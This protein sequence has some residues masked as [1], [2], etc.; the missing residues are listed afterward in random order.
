MLAHDSGAASVALL[1]LDGLDDGE[2]VAD[3]LQ[4]H[5]G[6]ELARL[7][8]SAP[9]WTPPATED[10]CQQATTSAPWP[11][12]LGPEV[13]IGV[14]GDFLDLVEEQTEADP[15]AMVLDFLTR[16]GNVVGR[17]PHFEVSGDRHCCNLF[18]AVVGDTGQGRK[19]TSTAFAR[20]MMA[21]CFPE[22]S[23][24]CNK[25][26]LSSGEGVIWGV[27]DPAP[28]GKVDKG[29]EAIMDPG[30]VDKRLLVFEAELARTLRA[31]GRR[32]NTLMTMLRQAWEGGQ[33]ATM[34]KTPYAATGAHISLIMHVTK[35]E[36][37]SL[38]SKDDMHGG[39]ANRLLF[40]VSRRQ[41]ELPFGGK[42]DDVALATIATELQTCVAHAEQ[43][44]EM[45]FSDAARL[46]WPAIYHELQRDEKA[47]GILGTLLARATAQVRRLAMIFAIID[48][49]TEVDEHHIAAA[50]EV[51]RYCRQ[52]VHYIFGY[53]TGNHVA[54]IILAALRKKPSGI[55]RT[56]MHALFGKH[57]SAR[58]IDEAL[59]LLQNLGLGEPAKV[60]GPRNG[61][62]P[63][64][65]VAT[66]R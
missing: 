16:V 30:V 12:P 62:P 43:R 2:D 34:T 14:L 49:N 48:D 7:V 50:R 9:T 35:E 42:V 51:W 19:G 13:R 32:D 36:L 24:H 65:W 31:G 28:S 40:C 25:G 21:M 5:S 22:W 20:R 41:R 44:G 1:K 33:L 29:G 60:S 27:R 46:A 37:R 57:V 17:A 52:S 55:N 4:S 59:A 11:K 18:S 38:L 6:A 10:A 63:Q 66:S 64:V 53:T 61:R 47:P 54:D 45:P 15:A 8:E 58:E 23:S 3:W 56:A 26:G 39:T